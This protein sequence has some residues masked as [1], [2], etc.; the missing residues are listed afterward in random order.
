MTTLQKF[1][2]GQPRGGCWCLELTDALNKFLDFS[3]KD[4]DFKF[5]NE[6]KNYLFSIEAKEYRT[7]IELKRFTDDYGYLEYL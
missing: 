6:S 5:S 4:K 3:L 2:G 7:D 1:P